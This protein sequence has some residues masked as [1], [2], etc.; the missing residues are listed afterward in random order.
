MVEAPAGPPTEGGAGGSRA[1]GRVQSVDRALDVLEALAQGGGPTGVAE[2]AVLTGLPQGTV[3][4]LLQSLQ[5]RG[6]VRREASRKY[7]LGA[8]TVRLADA[9]QRSL[10]RSARPFLAELVALSGETANLAVLEGDD[11][12]YVAQVPSPH[13]LRMFAE[14]GRHVPPH[15]TAVGKVLLAGLPRDR[16]LA[17]LRRTGLPARTPGTITDA[18]AFAAELDRV[19][20]TGWA[21]DEEEQEVGVRCVAVPVGDPG[22]VVAALSLSGPADRF[23]GGRTEG[24]VAEMQRVSRAFASG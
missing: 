9:A 19:Q 5:Q 1:P 22:G 16:A 15:S 8:S 6:Y 3:H 18:E 10:V 24:L 21:A 12:V 11:V 7:S 20:A 23:A 14:V 17:V 2:V 13:T 4:R